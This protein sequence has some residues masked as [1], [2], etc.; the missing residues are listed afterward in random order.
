MSCP[1]DAPCAPIDQCYYEGGVCVQNCPNRDP[2]LWCCCRVS[3]S[4]CP[5]GTICTGVSECT[6]A[7]GR[8]VASCPLGCCCQY[9]SP[10]SDN[11]IVYSYSVSNYTPYVNQ[12]VRIRATGYITASSGQYDFAVGV[13]YHDGPADVINSPCGI[14][15]KGYVCATRAPNRNVGTMWT[16]EGDYVFLQPGTYEIRIAAGYIVDNTL[17]VTHYIA[18]RISVQ[19]PPTPPPPPPPSPTPTPPSPPT[20][21]PTIPEWVIIAFMM[22][23]AM[24]MAVAVAVAVAARR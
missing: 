19:P 8:C 16:H 3:T 20:P 7:G 18:V 9:P 24:M 23:M 15:R 6:R 17:Y 5:S 14:L 22:M 2:R 4:E 21:G 10:P 13:A 12:P 1:S 11:A